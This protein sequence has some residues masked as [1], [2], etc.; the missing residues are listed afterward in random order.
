M[1][2]LD[3][4]FPNS[5]Q[6][7]LKS[8]SNSQSNNTSAQI[9]QEICDPR[10]VLQ[11]FVPA[12]QSLEW[13]IGAQHW[14]TA[15]IAPFIQNNVPFLINNDGLLSE[16]AAATFFANCRENISKN[17]KLSIIE[18]GA[19]SG[20]FARY[21][22][23]AFRDICQMN[24]TD[25]YARLT[26][27]VTDAS[28]KTVADWIDCKLFVD[29][30]N[31]VIPAI[32]SADSPLE[33]TAHDGTHL[34]L[35]NLMAVFCNYVLDVLPYAVIRKNNGDTEELQ[36]KTYLTNDPVLLAEYPHYSPDALSK[37][38][39]NIHAHSKEELER[40]MTVFEFESKFIPVER[41]IPFMHDT[42]TWGEARERVVLNYGAINLLLTIAKRITNT[43]FIMI[44]DY[45]TTNKEEHAAS[46]ISQ[47]FGATSAIGINFPLL[48]HVIRSNGLH[49]HEPLDDATRSIH[50]RLITREKLPNTVNLFNARF[51]ASSI[52]QFDVTIQNAHTTAQNG[53]I[54]ATLDLYRVAIEQQP[55]NWRLLA[56]IAEYLLFE[57]KDADAAL[58]LARR[59]VNVNPKL[60]PWLWNI[61]GDALWSL[62]RHTDAHIAYLE[63]QSIDPKDPR[64]HLNLAYTLLHQANYT[65]A[66]QAIAQGLANDKSCA[67]RERLLAKQQHILDSLTNRARREH[68][69]ALN[70]IAR[71]QALTSNKQSALSE[72]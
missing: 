6:A 1:D 44:N 46:G 58:E 29:H 35:P 34:T 57:I 52:N 54:A 16:L 61:L 60:S 7:L 41:H 28:P 25:D 67:Y 17:D 4:M 37:L 38:V 40:V 63:A 26:Y 65:A 33:L 70:R 50:T 56:E 11:D 21:F 15:G 2:L 23:D 49:I 62:D 64:T 22:M 53:D 12:N 66:L 59:A 20:L 69:H 10:T 30:G 9:I 18:Y 3:N 27:Y 24:K 19:G 51:S 72:T 32:C 55:R 36:I 14:R 48:E 42:I 68:D 71:L 47:R 39:K 43:G 45:G 8:L 31:H 5:T 13:E